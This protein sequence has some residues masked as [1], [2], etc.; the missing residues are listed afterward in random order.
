[1]NILRDLLPLPGRG[2]PWLPTGIVGGL[3]G[4]LSLVA[5]C[6]T[7]DIVAVEIEEVTLLPG[8]ASLLDGQSQQFVAIVTDSEGEVLRGVE[9]TWTTDDPAVAAIDTAGVLLALQ[10]GTTTVY[11]SFAGVEGTASVSVLP[12]P[13]LVLSEEMVAFI[14]VMGAPS[15]PPVVI[16]V[17]IEGLGTI[18]ELE[19]STQFAEGQPGGWLDATLD[20]TTAP[21]FLTLTPETSLMP[22]GTYDATVVMD[23]DRND[24][25]VALPVSLVVTVRG[26]TIA[27][28]D[29]A[30]SVTES[31]STDSFTVVLDSEPASDVVIEVVSADETEATVSP[32]ELKFTPLSWSVPQTVTVRGRNDSILDGDVT[33]AVSITVVDALS[34]PTYAPV[35]NGEVLVVTLDD[36]QAGVRV[37][38]TKRDTRVS[39]R[40]NDEIRVELEVEPVSDVVI[41]LWSEDPSKVAA[42]PTRLTFTPENWDSRQ[43][44]EVTLIGERQPGESEIT[45]IHFAVN[46]E[47]SDDGFDDLPDQLVEVRIE[48]GG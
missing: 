2:A 21:T 40:R 47:L 35:P 39:Q 24:D 28:S 37:R 17:S 36:E 46:D 29:G 27:E 16:D 10:E 38:E 6:T 15:P 43:V 25:P 7:H 12:G 42:S 23:S 45:F 20:A 11:A 4:T 34:D 31:G 26:V 13:T 14:A 41:D 48:G 32:S 9:V 3:L 5:G 1:M 33:T 22:A 8:T 18:S 30:T 44:V 19:V